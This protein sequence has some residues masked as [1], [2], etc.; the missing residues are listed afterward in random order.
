MRVLKTAGWGLLVLIGL[1]GLTVGMWLLTSLPQKT[2]SLELDGLT[3]TV[4]IYRDEAAIPYIYAQSDADGYFALG[5]VH[6]QDRFWQMDLMRRFG[7]GRLSELLGEATLASDRWMRTLGLYRRAE[8]QVQKLPDPVQQALRAYAKGVNAWQRTKN[9]LG[10]IEF[11]WFADQLDPW[12]PADSLIWSKIMA[13]RLSGNFRKEISRSRVADLLGRE[14]M[15]EFWPDD[16][17]PD[18]RTSHHQYPLLPVSLLS[19]LN[20][21]PPDP[22]GLPVGASNQWAIGPKRSTT[23]LPFLANDPHLGFAAPILWYLAFIKTPTTQLTGATVPGVPF[24]ILGH[25]GKIA[26]GIT[27]TQADQEDLVVE[28]V[29]NTN[30]A[31]YVVGSH[32]RAFIQTPMTIAVK[33]KP[34]HAMTVRATDQGPVISD[35]IPNLLKATEPRR[36]IVLEA[37]YLKPN[38]PTINALYYLNR[39]SN[40][41]EFRRAL[42]FLKTPTLNVSYADTTGNIGFQVAGSLPVRAVG[43]GSLP[44]RRLSGTANW[45]EYVPYSQLP[46]LYNPDQGLIFNANNP[47]GSATGGPF[48]SRDWAAPYRARRIDQVLQSKRKFDMGD[49]KT[50]QLDNL[51]LMAMDVLPQMLILATATEDRSKQILAMLK[52]WDRRMVRDRPEPLIFSTWL[53]ALN[54]GLYGDDLGELGKPLLGLRPLFVLNALQ[55][56]KIWCDDTQSIEKE[57]CSDIVSRSLLQAIQQLSQKYGNTPK[58]WRWGDAHQSTFAHGVFNHVPLLNKITDL[59]IAN[60]GGDYTVNR[61]ASRINHEQAPFKHIHGPGLRAIY[62]LSNLTRSQFQIA[63]GQSGNFLSSH[64]RDQLTNWR[65]GKFLTIDGTKQ[66]IARVTERPLILTAPKRP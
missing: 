46:H 30:S 65:D 7:A 64:Y 6:A 27:S 18:P 4:E 63:T 47:V 19:S 12:K 41:L 34:A 57:T 39:A 49:M 54:Y 55:E 11:V 59:Q 10:A 60:D 50:L 14:K 48:I 20:S 23:H 35:L 52:T 66:S 22:P 5:F 40:W 15:N 13:T 3:S 38:D 42:V 53:R 9:G 26:W 45:L 56:N 61:G 16:P 44:T 58:D 32:S 31:R 33:G 21:L 24:H 1:S 36:A 51:S 62:D 28:R 37:V 17:S 2:G 25:N 8:E 29:A 43:D